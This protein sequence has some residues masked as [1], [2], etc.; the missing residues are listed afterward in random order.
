MS[1]TITAD[2]VPDLDEWGWDDWWTCDQW[3]QWHA[4]REIAYG[5]TDAN[6]TFVDYWN[7]Q[8]MGAGAL[9]CRTFNSNFRQYCESKGLLGRL[10]D[11]G[12]IMQ[13][14]GSVLETA[15]DVGS[16]IGD[17]VTNLADAASNTSGTLKWL[18][19]LILI[20]VLA[21]LGIWAYKKY[22]LKLS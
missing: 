2:S 16:A 7:Q 8:S 19:P 21:G 1:Q 15:G 4:L 22:N 9:S 12:E 17:T 14:V 3:L 6:N 20:L 18:I 11:G 10:Y 5:L 13:P